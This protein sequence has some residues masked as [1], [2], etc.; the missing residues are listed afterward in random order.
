[1]NSIPEDVH[2]DHP[3]MQ[4]VGIPSFQGA[5]YPLELVSE[6]S[7]GDRLFAAFSTCRNE[8][9]LLSCQN[10]TSVEM[11][12]SHKVDITCCVN[13]FGHSHSRSNVSSVRK[14][15]PHW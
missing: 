6:T 9:F 15:F 3:E 8:H 1:M 11:I 2:G 4:P 7:R 12:Y 14:H 13:Q 10:L 5:Q